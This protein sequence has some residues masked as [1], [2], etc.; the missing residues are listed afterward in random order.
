MLWIKSEQILLCK[1]RGAGYEKLQSSLKL[2]KDGDQDFTELLV[3]DCHNDGWRGDDV[4]PFETK[5][6]GR[7]CGK[8]IL[9]RCVISMTRYK[10]P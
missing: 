6:L 2:F 7:Q 9:R 3:R 10:L 5:T 1:Q 8:S 4:E